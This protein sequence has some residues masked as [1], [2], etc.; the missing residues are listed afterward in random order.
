LFLGNKLF[1]IQ[2]LIGQLNDIQ[3]L[4]ASELAVPESDKESAPGSMM[5]SDNPENNVTANENSYVDATPVTRT[6]GIEEIPDQKPVEK[7]MTSTISSIPP[8][9]LDESE[10]IRPDEIESDNTESISE[11]V[12]TADTSDNIVAPTDVEGS[13]IGESAPIDIDHEELQVQEV[14]YTTL[15]NSADIITE[16]VD[17]TKEAHSSVESSVMDTTVTTPS[18]L[19]EDITEE[20]LE[21]VMDSSPK[22]PSLQDQS[23]TVTEVMEVT[24]V[25]DTTPSSSTEQDM[26][27]DIKSEGSSSIKEQPVTEQP[28][29]E[30]GSSKTD[31][32]IENGS[33]EVVEDDEDSPSEDPSGQD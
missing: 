3:A 18:V 6:S 29:T 33:K 28:V 10:N 25:T 4:Y 24:E 23:E 15:N 26:E 19:T 27:Q 12:D 8:A 31:R 14:E 20:V 22:D 9:S 11:T 13:S 30:E 2:S 1:H 32:S 21:P 7:E 17:E 5:G 16:Q